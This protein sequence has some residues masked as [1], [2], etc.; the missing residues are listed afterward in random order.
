MSEET[1]KI[2]E[3]A[4]LGESMCAD[5]SDGA[6]LGNETLCRYRRWR[7]VNPT[8]KFFGEIYRFASTKNWDCTVKHLKKILTQLIT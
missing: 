6:F 8:S 3:N 7:L 5:F 4:A 2:A 1:N